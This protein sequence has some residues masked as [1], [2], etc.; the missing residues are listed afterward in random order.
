MDTMKR[1]LY[2]CACFLLC[3]V[4]LVKAEPI[5]WKEPAHEDEEIDKRSISVVPVASHDR[6]I[7][8]IYFPVQVDYFR[9]TVK[10]A[11][12]GVVYTDFVTEFSEGYIFDINDCFS[13][14]DYLLEVEV[15]GRRFSGD[16]SL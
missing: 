6:G 1:L 10:D 4:S 2:V 9:V 8:S 14:G 12:G 5:G 13:E 15:S 3:F 16:F 7:I 11:A